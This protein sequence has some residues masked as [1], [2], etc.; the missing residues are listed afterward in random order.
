MTRAARLAAGLLVASV[1]WLLL[2][3]FFADPAGSA[4]AGV[5]GLWLGR[6]VTGAAFA[7]LRR[8]NT[9]PRVTHPTTPSRT[10]GDTP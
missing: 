1:A 9:V 10:A 8:T 4:L 5:A 6:P 7:R 2:V 3:A